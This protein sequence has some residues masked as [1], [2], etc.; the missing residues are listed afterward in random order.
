M[1][2]KMRSKWNLQELSMLF[3]ILSG[4]VFCVCY[5]YRQELTNEMQAEQIANIHNDLD[6]AMSKTFDCQHVNHKDM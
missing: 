2:K 5:L 4:F 6:S 3:T 1:N